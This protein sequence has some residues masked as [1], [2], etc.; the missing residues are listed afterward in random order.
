MDLDLWTAQKYITAL[1]GDCG[2]TRILDLTYTDGGGQQHASTNVDKGKVLAKTFF[3]DKPPAIVATSLLEAPTPICKANP[4]SRVQ[5]KDVLAR[6]KP[7]KA[8]GPDGIP[9]IVLLKCADIIESRLW[10]IY[11]AI[12]DKGWYYIT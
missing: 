9:N 8:P 2:R 12:V 7:F 6:L 10:F 5:I 3:S 1:P 11:T 4:I